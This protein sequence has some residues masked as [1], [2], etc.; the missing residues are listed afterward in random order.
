MNFSALWTRNED[1]YSLSIETRFT[2]QCY[3]KATGSLIVNAVDHFPHLISQPSEFYFSNYT[4]THNIG[5]FIEF[6]A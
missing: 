5:L 3:T 6:Y 2:S 1:I 4:H